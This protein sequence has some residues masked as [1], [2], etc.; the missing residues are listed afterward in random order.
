MYFP[1]TESFTVQLVHLHFP[2]ASQKDLSKFTQLSAAHIKRRENADCAS[3]SIF[4]NRNFLFNMFK[5]T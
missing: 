3:S 4:E 2:V 5:I 1:E